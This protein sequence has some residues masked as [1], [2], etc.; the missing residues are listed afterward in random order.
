MNRKWIVTATVMLAL[1]A[2][3]CNLPAGLSGETPAPATAAPPTSK[4]QP[5]SPPPTVVPTEVPR[6][7]PTHP[8]RPTPAAP[9][10]AGILFQDDFSDPDSG[11]EVGDY[12]TGSVG[13]KSGAYFVTSASDGST[14][15]GV[16]NRSF[17]DL[18]IE[19]DTTQISSPANNNNDYGVV[20]R[21]QG[22]GAGYYMLISGDGYYAIL[23][24]AA[25]RDFEPL[26]DWT[27]SDIIRQENATNHIR[28]VCDG[29]TLALFVNGQ[30]LATAED[31]AFSRGDV[32]LTATSYEDEPTE[33]HF[34]NLVIREPGV[35]PPPPSPA[36][37]S[38]DVLFQ[39]DFSDPESGWEVGDYEGGSVSYESG[40]Y[41]ARSESSGD[42]MWGVAGQHFTDIVM[43]VDATQV[44]GPSNDNNSYGVKCREQPNGGGYGLVIS[45]DGYYSIQIVV[46]EGDWDPLVDWTTSD[47]IRQGNGTNHIRAVCDGSHLALYVN[48][49]LLAETTDTT[50]SEGDIGLV[51]CTLEEDEPTEVHFDDL[52]VRRP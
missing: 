42:V 27:K 13:Y 38:A 17:D 20:C 9:A 46:A 23:V 12:D 28:A 36:T 5:T 10:S 2:L 33:T 3:A 37:P 18:F 47:V 48:G 40:I 26:V 50:Y 21:E 16:A 24:K 15:W 19:V 1:T 51:A 30:R 39:D 43:D 31:D 14:M 7:A 45:S 22:D 29:S 52:V 49:Q 41:F 6:E 8:S 32:A 44:L 34:D 4:P 25:G 11:W 35:L